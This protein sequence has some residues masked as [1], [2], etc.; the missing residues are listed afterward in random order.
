MLQNK[1]VTCKACRVMKQICQCK[2]GL[3]TPQMRATRIFRP[4]S[5]SLKQTSSGGGGIPS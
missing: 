3:Q 1:K 5:T 2:I 4:S